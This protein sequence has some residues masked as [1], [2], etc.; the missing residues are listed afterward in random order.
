MRF[1]TRPSRQR[2]RVPVWPGAAH[3]RTER[4]EPPC[5]NEPPIVPRGSLTQAAMKSC[6]TLCFA[7]ASIIVVVNVVPARLD[8]LEAA[9]I[10]EAR[11]R[12][13]DP[14]GTHL[15]FDDDGALVGFG[16][17]KGQPRDGEVE[18]G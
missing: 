1:R 10:D 8:W 6:A 13:E 7:A 15:F 17:L 18:L 3:E 4:A 16:G 5:P 2:S 11:R 12:S 9:V 14:W